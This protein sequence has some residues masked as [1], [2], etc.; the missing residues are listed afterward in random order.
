MNTSQI[1]C[2]RSDSNSDA[3]PGGPRRESRTSWYSRSLSRAGLAGALAVLLAAAAGAESRAAAATASAATSV[4]PAAPIPSLGTAHAP[5]AEDFQGR[6]FVASDSDTFPEDS[7][8]QLSAAALDAASPEW[9]TQLLVPPSDPDTSLAIKEWDSRLWLAFRAQNSKVYVTSSPDGETWDAWAPIPGSDHD[10]LGR[11]GVS[12]KGIGPKL[13]LAA[14][15]VDGGVEVTWR[16]AGGDWRGFSPVPD[17]AT[18]YRPALTQFHDRLTLGIVNPDGRVRI[19][20]S[21]NGRNWS[22]WID[23]PA[24][25]FTDSAGATPLAASSGPGLTVYLGA[26]YVGVRAEDSG[27]E[28]LRQVVTF[29][30]NAWSAWSPG[31]PTTGEPSLTTAAGDLIFAWKEGGGSAVWVERVRQAAEQ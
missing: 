15:S 13:Y 26:L 7:R 14:R 6:L 20:Q 4:W 3:V 19:N 23:A 16:T 12:L 27:G 8:F 9:A 25:G 2:S 29:D 10:E 1:P 5:N 21:S 28:A 24:L 22:S 18:R 31:P 11:G 30:G 17:S